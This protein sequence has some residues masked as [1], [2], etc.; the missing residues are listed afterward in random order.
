MLLR[1]KAFEAIPM[2]PAQNPLLELQMKKSPTVM[3][4]VVIYI[5][6]ST[7]YYTEHVGRLW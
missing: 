2:A 3:T 6:K 4:Q 1:Q 7:I 5:L